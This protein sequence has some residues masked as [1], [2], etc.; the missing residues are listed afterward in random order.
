M[1]ILRKFG[2]LALTPVL[3]S[4]AL[5]QFPGAPVPSPLPNPSP[6]PVAASPP[7]FGPV[8]AVTSA[9]IPGIGDPVGIA[10][11]PPP[12]G[13]S[14]LA[15]FFGLNNQQIEYRQRAM[16]R[17]PLGEL[18]SKIQTPLSKLTGGLIPPFPPMTPSLAELLA[19][20]PVGAAAKVKL[21]RAAAKDR[22]KAVQYLGT[23]DCHYWPE[24]T[25]GL[26]DALRS[27]RNE[28]VRLAAAQTL[29]KGCCCNKMTIMALSNV[30]SCSSEGG[31]IEKSPRVIAA[32][33]AALARCLAMCSS[34]PAIMAPVV[35]GTT[36]TGETG[37]KGE[38]GMRMGNDA[39]ASSKPGPAGMEKS[40][41]NLPASQIAKATGLEYYHRMAEKPWS[42]IIRHAQDVL[43]KAPQIPA[44]LLLTGAGMDLEMSGIQTVAQSHS[45]RPANVLDQLLGNDV[46][47][48]AVPAVTLVPQTTVMQMAVATTRPWPVVATDR[49]TPS[50]APK[51][52]ST[53]VAQSQPTPL[54]PMPAK[55][56]QQTSP[57]MPLAKAT[58]A[59]NSPIK[60]V[61]MLA[62]PTDPR[63]LE[64]AIDAYT[65]QE[66]A[67]TPAL[68]P[69][70]LKTAQENADSGL[71]CACVRALVRGKIATPAVLAGLDK[72][73]SDRAIDVRVEAA[74]GL[75]ELK[76]GK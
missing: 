37:E 12:P 66:I 57:L 40:S 23:V 34:S 47:P 43:A 7:A 32:A 52:I 48:V 49:S 67:A 73:V 70:L 41:G 61:A 54:V 64:T 71:R 60:L 76:A 58:P 8:G 6:F 14:T 45:D 2:A 20:G 42:Y 1:S 59:T 69:A 53:T 18:R 56:A 55:L 9:P 27:D 65:A 21:D 46:Q 24:A 31:P 36:G 30:V 5:A 16:A 25:D 51:V 39:V 35:D 44:E 4:A 3:A 74:V 38:R 22:I 63:Q 11:Y 29:G 28:W 68:A 13:G 62:H 17:T 19:P 33:H 75:N 15:S 10:P 72:L 26:I 50:P